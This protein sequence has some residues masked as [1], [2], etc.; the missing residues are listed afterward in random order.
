LQRETKLARTGKE[1]EFGYRIEEAG[2]HQVFQVLQLRLLLRLISPA[3]ERA[4]TNA[5]AAYENLLKRDT[6]F[7]GEDLL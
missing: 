2:R 6:L 5:T 7:F 1:V 3:S 4:A